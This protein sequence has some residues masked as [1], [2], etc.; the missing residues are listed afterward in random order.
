MHGECCFESEVLAAV[1]ECRWPERVE[2][3]LRTH[4]ASCAVCSDVALLATALREDRDVLKAIAA[5]PESGRVWWMAQLRARREAEKAASRPITAAQ[6]VGAAATAWFAGAC[7]GASSDWFRSEFTRLASGAESVGIGVFLT[8]G[9]GLL[10]LLG[11]VSILIL[12]PAAI[13]L[14]VGKD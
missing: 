12:I 2:P 13:W 11:G 5:P 14:A 6:V 4:A 1:V 10:L 8:S 9:A 7:F 3:E